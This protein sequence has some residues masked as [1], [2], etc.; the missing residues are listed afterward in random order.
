MIFARNTAPPATTCNAVV[1]FYTPKSSA[2]LQHNPTNSQLLSM[3]ESSREQHT[4]ARFSSSRSG[5][6]A[7]RIASTYL[8]LKDVPLVAR[9]RVTTLSVITK[10]VAFLDALPVLPSRLMVY[11]PTSLGRSL[12]ELKAAAPQTRRRVTSISSTAASNNATVVLGLCR[13]KPF[14]WCDVRRGLASTVKKS[15]RH[16]SFG[17][18]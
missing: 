4:V 13:L 2:R 10:G 12:M 18:T 6:S 3:K 8:E 1:P 17:Q 9:S 15:D 7:F 16:T 11:P 14:A 5:L